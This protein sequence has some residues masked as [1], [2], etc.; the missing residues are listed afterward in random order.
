MMKS[1]RK[2][3]DDQGTEAARRAKTDPIA[4]GGEQ[5]LWHSFAALLW[6]S[7]RPADRDRVL[8]GTTVTIGIPEEAARPIYEVMLA[9]SKKQPGKLTGPLLASFDLDSKTDFTGP[10]LR[11]RA[12]AMREN[13]CVGAIGVLELTLPKT[14]SRAAEAPADDPVL[15]SDIGDSGRFSGERDEVLVKLAR[16][17][18]IPI[19]SR[20]R[21]APVEGNGRSVNAGGRKLSEVMADLATA[22]DATIHASSRGYQLLRSTT[23]AMDRLG[24]PEPAVVQAYLTKRP[25]AGAVPFATLSELA[26][27]SPLQLNVLSRNHTC[28][29][30]A[31][32]AGKMFAVLRFYRSLTPEQRQAL[33]STQ[34][35]SAASLTHEQIHQF[36]DEKLKRASFDIHDQLQ[37]LRGLS[38]R[39]REQVQEQEYVLQLDAYRDGEVKSHATEALPK[40]DEDEGPSAQR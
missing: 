30:D 32:E 19:L 28:G 5:E 21:P 8:S 14:P 10:V 2:Q 26:P 16:A 31:H 29:V 37:M 15:P 11:A 24:I 34:G 20:H 38:F 35:L 18:G 4:G 23:E 17:T 1:F 22:C 9:I 36:L 12:T 13:S 39:F 6:N 27:L 7:L 40:I 25:K 33:F 3:L